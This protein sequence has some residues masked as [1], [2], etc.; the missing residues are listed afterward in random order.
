MNMI[1][2]VMA[3][4]QG[5]AQTVKRGLP[6]IVVYNTAAGVAARARHFGRMLQGG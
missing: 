5:T 4:E 3:N 2:P 1:P 6:R